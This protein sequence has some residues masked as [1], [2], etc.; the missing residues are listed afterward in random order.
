MA[1]ADLVTSERLNAFSV[2]PPIMVQWKS[3]E[4]AGKDTDVGYDVWP[5]QN[6]GFAH[7][8]R[9]KLREEN[10]VGWTLDSSED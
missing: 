9:Y 8:L 1:I 10:Q 2:I 3:T 7:S 4:Q 5:V 6:W